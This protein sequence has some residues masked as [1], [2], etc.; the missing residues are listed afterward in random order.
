M[1]GLIEIVASYASKTD[2]VEAGQALVEARLAAC[3]Q[4]TGP[5]ESL[6]I[7]RG[8]FES[9]AEWL[10]AAKTRASL[11]PLAELFL[12]ERHSYDTPQIMALP[13]AAVSEAYRDWVHDQT[14]EPD[15][16]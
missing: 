6:Y 16:D 7:W 1:S 12:R 8:Q 14:R 2:A 9:Q 13:I 10:L 5:A 15:G 11:W 3:A 4:I